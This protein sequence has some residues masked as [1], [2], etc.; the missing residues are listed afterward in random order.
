MDSDA[1]QTNCPSSQLFRQDLLRDSGTRQHCRSNQ[2]TCEFTS[3][4]HSGPS[5]WLSPC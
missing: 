2:Q 5:S 3:A 4:S 1:K